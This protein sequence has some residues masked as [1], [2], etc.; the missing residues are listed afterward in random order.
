[1]RPCNIP[2]GGLFERDA[3][4]RRDP[5]RRPLRPALFDRICTIKFEPPTIRSTLSSLGKGNSVQG[6][7]PHVSFLA[8]PH[9]PERPGRHPGAGDLKVKTATIGMHA[10]PV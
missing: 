1:L 6:A 4:R 8:V 9:K 5:I 10:R 7:K 3:F 2:I